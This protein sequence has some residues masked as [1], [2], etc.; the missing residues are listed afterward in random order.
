MFTFY[1]WDE[2][3]NVGILARDRQGIKPCFY[4][5][6]GEGIAYAS[7]IKSILKLKSYKK[8]IN[9]NAL[10]EVFCFNYA[11]PYHTCFKDIYHLEPGH[12]I[13]IQHGAGISKHKYWDWPFFSERQNITEDY[14][15]SLLND[16]I[17]LQ[18][19]FDVPGGMY[20]S[21]GVDSSV[22]AYGLVQQWHTSDL[23]ALGLNITNLIAKE[24]MFNHG[25]VFR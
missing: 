16:A 19:R 4:T 24:I 15:E 17:R 12:Y 10:K 3:Q 14:F 25:G 2:N 20:L 11:T 22:I 9:Y 5:K 8:E 13:K 1:L 23:T 7:E 6:I 18:M 21:G